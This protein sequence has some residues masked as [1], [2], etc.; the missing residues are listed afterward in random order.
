MLKVLFF[1]LPYLVAARLAVNNEFLT[2]ANIH[3]KSYR[4]SEELLKRQKIYEEND[5]MIK[6]H[7]S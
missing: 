7:N 6:H 2:Y 3:G 4:S 1:L 5:K